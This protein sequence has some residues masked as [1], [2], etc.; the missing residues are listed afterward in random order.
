MG[1]A[2]L[3]EISRLL[4]DDACDIELRGYCA[5][6]EIVFEE[7]PF[8]RSM[9]LSSGRAFAVLEALM[10][11]GHIPSKKIVAHGFGKNGLKIISSFFGGK[12]RNVFSRDRFQRMA[13]EK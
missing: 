2:F 11:E 5:P 7:N 6:S 9:M 10:K 12:I 8:K 3:K 1:S 4:K 13:A